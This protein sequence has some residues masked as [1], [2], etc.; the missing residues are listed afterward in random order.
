MLA[1]REVL[2]RSSTLS[3]RGTNARTKVDVLSLSR[4]WW[5]RSKCNRLEA[6]H[7]ALLGWQRLWWVA[8]NTRTLRLV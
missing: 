5:P 6:E 4:S 3:F 8:R 7:Q 2:Q 1:A